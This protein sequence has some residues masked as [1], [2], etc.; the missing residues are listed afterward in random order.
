MI[1]K[2]KPNERL[3]KEFQELQKENSLLKAIYDKDIAEYKQRNEI[4]QTKIMNFEAVFESSP[5]AMFIIDETTNIAM[6]NLAALKLCGGNEEEILQHRPGNALRC[7][8]SAKDP[9]GCGYSPDCKTCEVRNAIE[10]LIAKGGAVSG[11]ELE[12]TLNHDTGPRSVWMNVGIEPLIK[13]G[14]KHWCIAMSD[15][16]ESKHIE[17]SLRISEERFRGIFNNLQDAFLQA[18]LSGNF[19]L[20]SPSALR[21][22]GYDSIEEMISMPASNL[23]AN[24]DVRDRLINELQSKGE[25]TDFVGEGKR[26]DGSTFWVSMNIRLMYQNGK[27]SGTEGIVRDITERK[28]AEKFIDDLI[29]KNPL[30][31]QILDKD[32]FTLKVNTAHS[33]LFGAP[34]PSNFSI[35][36]DLQ[37]K[38]FGEHILIAKK[39]EVVHFPD[40][41]YNVHDAFPGLPDKPVWIRAVLFPLKDATGNIERFVFM[42]EDITERKQ[43]EEKL[44]Q[45]EKKYFS[46]FNEMLNGFAFHKILLDENNNPFDYT[47]INVNPAFEHLTGLRAKDIIGKTALELMP[48]NDKYWAEIYGKVALTGE[49]IQFENFASVLNKHFSIVAYCPE[50]GYFATIFEDITERKLAEEELKSV[51]TS[52]ELC[53]EASQIGIWS[54]DLIEDPEHI[55]EVSVRDLKHDQIFGY[56]EK[57]ASWGQEKMLEHVIDEDREATRKAF[58]NV[59]EKGRLDFECRILWPDN[60]I[61]WIAC[62]GKVYKDMAGQPNRI[63]GTVMDIT[64]RKLA[65]QE[66][67]IAKEHA[68]ESEYRLKLATASGQLGIWDWNLI[69]NS[70]IWDDRMF[71]LYGIT[72]DTFPNNIDAWTNGLHPE[73]KQMALDECNAALNGE[74]EF[75]ASFRVLHPNGTVLYLKANG[76]VIRDEN[77]KPQRMIGINRDITENR[78]AAKQLL[79]EKEKA[80][81]S[82]RLKSAFLAN[83]SHEIRTP[84]NSIIGF[85]ELLNDPDFDQHQKDKFTEAIIENGNNLLVIISDIIDLSMLESRQIKIKK[86]RFLTKKL[87]VDIDN[88]FRTKANSKVLKFLVNTPLDSEEM[89]IESDF[90]R[91]KQVFNNL[92]GN[93]LKFTHNGYIEIGFSPIDKGVEFFVRDSGIGIASEFHEDIFERFRQ[94]DETKTRK[95][96]GNGLG[97]AISKNLVEVLGGK[98]RVESEIGKGSTFSFSLPNN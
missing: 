8:H 95:Y 77:G 96:G 55:K 13:D 57:L 81:E 49:S 78:L 35:F 75:N 72:R 83:M 18:D 62:R 93:A 47:F 60:T 25:I 61:H 56:K 94:V 66:L 42:H 29:E 80:E 4:L 68:E 71:E 70:M 10:S 89:I 1:D 65:E 85:S 16:S 46:L 23:Y 32:G 9:R 36:A 69:E 67:I 92:I 30:S 73:D 17:E 87:L 54:H 82:D 38:G 52:L 41:Y 97:L 34:P 86:E 2:D 40:I 79:I 51:K 91:I 3:V 31:I 74:K 27:I 88:E 53:L 7:V 63:N 45:S 43:S 21:M 39:G 28:L 98:I 20:V 84:L 11:A 76:S 50:I 37:N 22:Y 48:E 33:G 12:F 5:V 14:I 59:F 90:Y 15:I 44:Q 6:V 24:S 58:G 19:T 64:E 26:K